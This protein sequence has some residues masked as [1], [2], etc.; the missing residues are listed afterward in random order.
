MSIL[1]I[2]AVVGAIFGVVFPVPAIKA[3]PT[4]VELTGSFKRLVGEKAFDNNNYT[5]CHSHNA[6]QNFI[7]GYFNERICPVSISVINGKGEN[8][9]IWLDRANIYMV[10]NGTISCFLSTLIYKYK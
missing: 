7:A 5:Y 4:R 6:V 9:A 3:H 8:N 2:G 10:E 1:T